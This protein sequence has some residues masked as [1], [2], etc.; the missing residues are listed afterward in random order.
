MNHRR[1][2]A[3]LALA[4]LLVLLF[5]TPAFASPTGPRMPGPKRGT[6][7]NWSGYA[8][9]T[10][11]SSPQ[12]G[13]VS[14]V[15]ATWTVTTV[16]PTAMNSWS[17]TWVGIDGYSSGS[18]EQIGTE[19]DWYNGTPVYY[20]WYEMYPKASV[21]IRALTIRPGDVISA[22]VNYSSSRKSSGFTLTLKDVT[23][24]KSFS[25]LMKSNA[26]RSSAEWVVEAPWSGGVLPLANFGTVPFS[27]ASATINGHTG[28]ISDAAW[29]NDPITMV[30]SSGHTLAVPSALSL[31]G[32]SFSDTWYGSN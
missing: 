24:G 27:S 26:K 20:A 32:S 22:E 12:S 4:S 13:A 17:S 2:A 14:D 31:A 11:L 8:A 9:E 3:A 30:S 7:T 19:A 18:V 25:T 23:T 5:A 10:N 6:S 1:I 16:T 29:Q 15:K 21:T 28:G